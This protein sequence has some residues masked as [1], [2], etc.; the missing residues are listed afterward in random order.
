MGGEGR[1]IKDQT[2]ESKTARE[3]GVWRVLPPKSSQT[4]PI[5]LQGWVCPA[6]R[7]KCVTALEPWKKVREALSCVAPENTSLAARQECYMQSGRPETVLRLDWRE[8]STHL[9]T[10]AQSLG[11]PFPM[12]RLSHFIMFVLKLQG[13]LSIRAQ[14]V[15]PFTVS[16]YNLDQ[17][18]NWLSHRTW[19]EMYQNSLWLKHSYNTTT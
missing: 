18:T 19:K 16:F 11:Y 4:L 14:E 3:M 10:T 15:D 13:A 7:R 12:A 2:I 9:R 5:R 6:K 1:K 8:W 17:K